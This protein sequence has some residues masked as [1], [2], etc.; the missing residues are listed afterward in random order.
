MR[1]EPVIYKFKLDPNKAENWLIGAATGGGK[2][3]FVK[4]I[5]EWMLAEGFVVTI[6]DYEGD[7]YTELTNDIMKTTPDKVKSISMGK[8]SSAYVDPMRIPDITGDPDIDD[9]LKDTAINFAVAMFR[10]MVHGADGELT[11]WEDSVISQAISRVFDEYGVTDDKETWKNSKDI[12]ISDVYD[13]IY[14]MVKNM[15]LLDEAS[16][17]A[18]HKAAVEIVEACRPYFEE[19][20]SKAGTFKQP[21]SVSD[22]QG[23]KL[24]VFRFGAKGATASS[25][26]SNV[27]A[28]K[29]LSVANISTQ[30]SN[31]CKYVRH[32]FN[33][34]VW[35]EYQRY[36]EI[37]G[38]AEIIANSMTGG[39]K[40]GD[41]NLIITNDLSNLLRDDI[42]IN[43]TLMQSFT[44][45]A[46]GKIKYADTITK[47]CEK[48]QLREIQ[49]ELTKISKAAEENKMSKYSHAFCLVLDDGKRA[50]VKTTLPK[51][52]AES[53]LFSTG[54][55]I[56]DSKKA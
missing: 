15:T 39:R 19:G 28:L 3:Y 10:I 11:R 24:I 38:S 37:A 26:N 31:Y 41:I 22:V 18:K 20:G 8:G 29:Q 32:C 17:N 16:D 34:K 36:G 53:D 14:Q 47:L 44:S 1:K 5:L 45:Y 27:M 46:I 33:V 7:E 49:G 43:E 30:I 2:S 12:R 40:R 48:L 55:K 4:A 35:E 6:M 50:V 23:A 51:K 56:K 42:K 54:V 13:N 9:D 52:I 21:I 25:T